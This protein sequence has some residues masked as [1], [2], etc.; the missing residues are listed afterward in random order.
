MVESLSL[1][2][3]RLRALFSYPVFRNGHY[4][5]VVGELQA[6]GIDLIELNGK[7][8]LGNLNILG[9]G[10]V[11]LVAI[12]NRRGERVAVKILRADANRA[13]LRGEAAYL[14]AANGVG[15]GPKLLGEGGAVLAMEYI[16]GK[17]LSKWLQLPHAKEEVA[18]VLRSLLAQ[19][20]RLDSSGID[21][22][23]LSDAKKHVIVNCADM[24]FIIDFETASM[25]R[26]CRNLTAMVN[27]L[28]FKDSVS[29]LTE[30]Y[31]CLEREGLKDALREYKNEPSDAAYEKMMALIGLGL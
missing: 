31:I 15:V 24:P 11:G 23:E 27:Y 3:G 16:E 21:H 12:G 22:G 14:R 4:G 29:M 18:Y 5:R 1:G 19:C 28:F 26:A 25:R 30:R 20:R 10:C 6:L 2:D 7:Q 9:K 13:N 8:E 17:F